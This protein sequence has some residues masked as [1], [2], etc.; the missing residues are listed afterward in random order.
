MQAHNMINPPLEIIR[1]STNRTNARYS[2]MRVGAGK[3]IESAIKLV[4]VE[5]K[6]SS[7]KKIM[8]RSVDWGYGALKNLAKNQSIWI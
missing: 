5:A 2:V 7:G 8:I 4:S 1:V 6:A 3:L